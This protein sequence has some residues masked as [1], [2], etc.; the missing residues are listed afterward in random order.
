[1]RVLFCADYVFYQDEGGNVYSHPSVSYSR[2]KRY[3][4]VF[5][6]FCVAAR[7][8]VLDPRQ[9][10]ENLTISGGQGVTFVS[11]PNLSN[12]KSLLGRAEAANLLRGAIGQADAVIARLPSEIGL[13]A[14]KVAREMEK[15]LAAEVVSNA[16]GSLW[17]YGNWKGKLYAPVIS[18]RTRSCIRHTAFTL[19]VS[20]YLKKCYP[21]SGE[22]V[23]ISDVE[24]PGS[25][26]SVLE[27]RIRKI[28]RQARPL[29]FGLIGDYG[30][31][32]KGIQTAVEAL[33][34]VRGH[35]APFELRV[36]GAGDSAPYL[37]QAVRTGLA[38]SIQFPKLLPSGEPVLQ[39]LD[40][41]DIY[42]QPSLTEGQGNA[43]LEA[44]SRGCP[45]IGSTA[46]GIPELL[47]PECLHNAGDAVALGSLILDA[48]SS[49]EWL[50]AQARRNF[51]KAREYTNATLQPRRTAFWQS[52]AHYSL[53]NVPTRYPSGQD[54]GQF[55]V[56]P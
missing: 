36:L 19:Y 12:V 54:R 51:E 22:T 44:M 53:R 56:G 26:T 41:V 8:K 33:S 46:G 28:W 29:V 9:G 45:A 40:Q 55:T 10:R 35:L 25:N 5:D 49:P 48:V 4:E 1:M 14:V 6:E 30:Q 7:G 17:H 2:W 27:H 50:E 21:A 16:W 13:L 39:W 34:R 20:S 43:L 31:R 11:I 38:G 23:V 18:S 42:L 24:L 15:P 52:F 32:Y 37:A 3:L 47:A